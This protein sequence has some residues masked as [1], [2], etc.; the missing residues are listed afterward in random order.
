M[1]KIVL[2]FLAASLL[3]M[4]SCSKSVDT[5]SVGGEGSFSLQLSLGDTKAAMS[6]EEL[7]SSSVVNIY[8]AD[9]SGLVRT[10][11]YSE[12]P[13][14]VYLPVADYRV[15]VIAG[16]AA[17]ATPVRATWDSKSYK[18]SSPVSIEAGKESS[19]AVVAKVSNVVSK[20][21]FDKTVG[22]NFQSG[23]TLT[24]GAED[25]AQLVY[26]SSKSGAEGYF[27]ITDLVDPA[28]TWTFSGKLAKDGTP[29]EK[30]GSIEEI[31]GGKLYNLSLKYTVKDGTAAF[32][33]QVD[34]GTE[35]I[36]DVVVFEASSTGLSASSPYE[37]WAGHFTAHADVDESE[38][39]DPS[40]IKFAYSSNGTDWTTVD[41]NRTSEGVYDA[42]F[43]KLTP[44]TEYQYKLVINGQDMGDALSFTTEAALTLP[45][46]SLDYSST[47]ASG[48]FQEFYD[49]SCSDVRSQTAWWGS[50]N[51][52]TGIS[53]AADLGGIIIC[54]PDESEKIDGKQSACLQSSYAFSKFA[55]G[56]LFCGY[57]G[58]LEGTKGGKVFFGRPF[59][60]R[61]THLRLYMKYSA[62]KVNRIESY[63]PSDPVTSND[64]DRCRIQCA[65]GAWN[66]KK[67]GGNSEC[68]VLVNT[69]KSET[70]ID[71][72]T[73]AST[74]GYGE[75]ILQSDAN[76]KYNSWIQYT[77]PINYKNTNAYPTH[78]I[79]SM[80]AS[81]LGDYFTGCDTA[82]LWV[83]KVELL[84]E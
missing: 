15:D 43:K 51:G 68:P 32:D 31:V 18:G 66:Y 33:V 63:P 41:A 27:I 16:E 25:G 26:D 77:I 78:I 14:K 49:P 36:S 37:I 82:K 3:A 72:Y 17:K 12:A 9:F 70:F 81:M 1:K 44:S 34:Y 76:N 57:F 45:N 23:Y 28:L 47:S 52:S 62:G 50:G 10:Y 73:D 74:Y 20:V 2:F 5:V 54:K 11:K 48:K 60:A 64:Y 35:V 7:L 84:Y 59:A 75:L 79:I 80:A 67:Y 30:T 8:Y 56:N 19:V 13:A 42:V 29:F 61:P 58:G 69:T 55:A 24:I 83:D 38:F 22:E 65:I 46:G 53:G 6:D 4:T 71:Y 21:T 40:K 39:S